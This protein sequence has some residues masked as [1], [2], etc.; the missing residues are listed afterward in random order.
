MGFVMELGTVFVYVLSGVAFLA[1]LW[2]CIFLL[3][4]VGSIA[5]ND[6]GKGWTVAFL[7]L[8]AFIV[9]WAFN[10]FSFLHDV[11]AGQVFQSGY[12]SASREV[13][14]SPTGIGRFLWIGVV[15]VIYLLGMYVLGL[16]ALFT[17]S[18]F[19][20]NYSRQ[21]GTAAHGA[22]PE[23]IKKA[24]F[25]PLFLLVG[26]LGYLWVGNGKDWLL[27]FFL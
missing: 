3:L 5:A 23:R 21:F 11:F 8:L 24:V 9:Y 12:W 25:V 16:F 18:G 20:D 22:V 15:W 19:F 13:E 2:L 7:S 6:K 27:G 10:G 17:L 4:P 26:Y 1:V 14:L